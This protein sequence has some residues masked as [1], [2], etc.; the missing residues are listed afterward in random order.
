MNKTIIALVIA[1]SVAA[2][3]FKVGVVS[4]PHYNKYYNPLGSTDDNCIETVE[5]KSDYPVGRYE[6]D[7]SPAMFHL[8]MERFQAVFGEVDMLLVPGDHVAHK[9]SSKSDD[10]DHSAYNAVK[11]NLQDTWDVLTQYF[12][13]TM[14]LPTLGNNDGRFH[15]QAIDESDKSD[16]YPYLY[17]LWF[18][19][20]AGNQSFDLA[21]IE[22]SLLKAGYYRADVTSKL[23]VLQMNSMYVACDDESTHDG[24]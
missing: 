24:E 5:S 3:N 19:D 8:L 10:S 11:E 21:E 18:K 14:I 7:N 16:Y 13:N 9:V 4:D 15:D 6:C 1:A 2:R 20:F 12:P 22:K 23:T 17:D